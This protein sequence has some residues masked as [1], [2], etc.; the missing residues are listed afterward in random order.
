MYFPTIAVAAGQW[1]SRP[2]RSVASP[3]SPLIE[4]VADAGGSTAAWTRCTKRPFRTP[5][6]GS[7]TTGSPVITDGEQ[8]KYH[9]FWTYCVEGLPNTAP[10]GFQIPFAAGHVRRMPRLT[11]GPFRYQTLCG[12]LPRRW[13]WLYA[14]PGETGGHLALRLEPDVSS[15]RNS[16]LLAG[17]SFIDDLLREHETEVRRCLKKGAHNVQIDFT[18]A[19]LAIK[20]DPSG[21]SAHQFHR[22]E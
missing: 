7:R 11:S 1:T 22:P 4:A 3:S 9:N 2:N 10:D 20:L 15:R 8:R 18:E 5:S 16:R 13:R 21:Q 12:P 19:R 6:P 14:R 17:S